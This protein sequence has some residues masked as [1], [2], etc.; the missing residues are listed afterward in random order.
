MIARLQAMAGR[1]EAAVSESRRLRAELLRLPDESLDWLDRAIGRPATR[2]SQ[3]GPRHVP[4][5][6]CRFRRS[7]T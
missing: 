5:V 2:G 4:L 6:G 3:D 7:S 1:L